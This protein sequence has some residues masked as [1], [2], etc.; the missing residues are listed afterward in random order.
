MTVVCVGRYGLQIVCAGGIC[1]NCMGRNSLKGIRA[2]RIF[3]DMAVQ[4]FFRVT[5]ALSVILTLC[6][7]IQAQSSSSTVYHQVEGRLKVGNNPA[8]NVRV[9][10]M[11]E[12]ERRPIAETFSRSRGEFEFRYVTEGDY[13]IETFETDQL[14]ASSTIL[15]VRPFPRE[16]PTSFRVDIDIAVK[17]APRVEVG[18]VMADVDINVPKE[19]LKHYRAGMKALGDD[20]SDHAIAELQEA[21]KTYSEYYAARLQLGRELRRLKRSKEAEEILR[22]LNDIA[23]KRVEARIEYGIALLELQRRSE[24]AESLLAAVQLEEANWVAHF[25][26]GWALL[27]ERAE[28]AE[29]HLKRALELDKTRAVRAYLALARIANARGERE[30]AIEYLDAYVATDP[31]A[32]DAEQAR[33]L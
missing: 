8:V 13:I 30:R 11:R 21:V 15:H 31:N 29:H 26:L 18:V 9:R 2:P 16:I 4:L 5:L 1:F 17:V 3:L 7:S 32:A 19:A 10:I 12:T 14:E 33:Q 22:P 27:E 20:K 24:A 23:P 25:Y 6:L 28:E